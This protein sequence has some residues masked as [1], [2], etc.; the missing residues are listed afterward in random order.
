MLRAGEQDVGSQ[1]EENRR[2][3]LVGHKVSNATL[4]PAGQVH[5]LLNEEHDSSLACFLHPMAWKVGEAMRTC[6]RLKTDTTRPGYEHIE[7]LHSR[8]KFAQPVT[9]SGSFQAAERGRRLDRRGVSRVRVS[10][11]ASLEAA[12]NANIAS[13]SDSEV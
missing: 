9:R 11:D 1:N 5:A 13:Y 12:P 3:A 2:S 6:A 4:D 8:D 7:H 10:S